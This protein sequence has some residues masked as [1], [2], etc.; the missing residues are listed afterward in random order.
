M[1]KLLILTCKELLHFLLFNVIYISSPSHYN[2]VCPKGNHSL[3][4][5][6]SVCHAT[7]SL[8]PPV[9]TLRDGSLSNE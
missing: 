9:T 2:T 8:Q 5:E 4:S 6:D 3:R 1:P 7:P